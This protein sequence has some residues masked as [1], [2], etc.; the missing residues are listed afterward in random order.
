MKLTA[1]EDIDLPAD[2][3]FALLSDMGYYERQLMRRGIDVTRTAEGE[4]AE[5]LRWEVA[6]LPIPQIETADLWIAELSPPARLAAGAR[7]GG[8]T[9][10]LQAEV[11]ALSRNS[12]RLR[13]SVEL[14]ASGLRNTAALAA[15]RLKAPAISKTFSDQVGRIAR[16]AERRARDGETVQAT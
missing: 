8:F 4:R 3:A 15:L 13:V 7:S 1:T 9:L 5:D 16:D 2:R 10:D 11:T 14:H 6:V 12:S